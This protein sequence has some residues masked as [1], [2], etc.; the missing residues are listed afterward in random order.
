M[1]QTITLA[2]P[3]IRLS[4]NGRGHHMALARLVKHNRAVAGWIAKAAGCRV[5]PPQIL[6]VTITYHPPNNRR[7]R[8]NVEATMK[9][10]I[11]GIAEVIGI[12]DGKWRISHVWGDYDKPNGKVVVTLHPIAVNVELR[13][14]IR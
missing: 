10:A 1:T 8:Q 9:A 4:Q 14:V 13:G 11:D 7:D 3:D 12:N 2:W 5:L 6:P